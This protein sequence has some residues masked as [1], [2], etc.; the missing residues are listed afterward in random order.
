LFSALKKYLPKRVTLLS[1]EKSTQQEGNYNGKRRGGPLFAWVYVHFKAPLLK[2]KREKKEKDKRRCARR[3]VGP[4]TSRAAS[5][6]NVNLSFRAGPRSGPC[7]RIPRSVDILP[8]L[9]LQLGFD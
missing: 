5:G 6:G 3:V 4:K 8:S 7:K 2:E 1:E 9:D